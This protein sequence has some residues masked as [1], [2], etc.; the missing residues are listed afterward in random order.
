MGGDLHSEP[1]SETAVKSE[2]ELSIEL[3]DE[4]LNLILYGPP[5]K[6]YDN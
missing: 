4:P 1:I 2:E 5:G 3:P 6:Q